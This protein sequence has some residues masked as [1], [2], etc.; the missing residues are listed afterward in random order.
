MPGFLGT[1]VQRVAGGKLGAPGRGSGGYLGRAGV[2]LGGPLLTSS[3]FATAVDRWP[4]PA[5]S[6]RSPGDRRP[7][8]ALGTPPQGGYHFPS[9][10]R[11]D[12][13]VGVVSELLPS[14]PFGT[15]TQR[16]RE[17]PVGPPIPA[18]RPSVPWRRPT[19][20]RRLG[21]PTGLQSGPG[22]LDAVREFLGRESI[23]AAREDWSRAIGGHQPD[24]VVIAPLRL[25]SA[26]TMITVHPFG[27]WGRWWELPCSA[28]QARAFNCE[29]DYQ[30]GMMNC[31][32]GAL[33]S[34]LVESGSWTIA[35]AE[36]VRSNI[37]S[38]AWD[39]ETAEWLAFY[40]NPSCARSVERA[41]G[42]CMRGAL[43]ACP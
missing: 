37:P 23:R 20:D 18:I 16:D 22:Q 39:E 34:G 21:L 33:S 27:E 5:Q 32:L 30:I 36:E 42:R 3:G 41:Y 25:P 1:P 35:H 14:Y 29:G 19:I 13:F 9:G 26:P 24:V 38:D 2:W 7:V 43:A 8:G 15:R 28:G 4:G 40:L 31:A 17:F 11:P 10:L 12:P 6:S